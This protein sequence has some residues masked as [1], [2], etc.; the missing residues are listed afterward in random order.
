MDPAV[1]VH[2][3]LPGRDMHPRSPHV[4]LAGLNCLPP[5]FRPVREGAFQM[6]YTGLSHR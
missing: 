3:A 4:V 5:G 1:L 2:D 6:A